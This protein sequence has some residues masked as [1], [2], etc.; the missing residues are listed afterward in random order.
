MQE[1]N[2][3]KEKIINQTTMIAIC[4]SSYIIIA[5]I[6]IMLQKEE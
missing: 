5:K 1:C 6:Q 4:Q 3:N 2:V